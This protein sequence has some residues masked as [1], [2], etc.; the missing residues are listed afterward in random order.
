LFDGLAVLGDPERFCENVGNLIGRRNISEMD[1]IRCVNFA[2]VVEMRIDMLRTGVLNIIL[3]M[4]V[5]NVGVGE[6]FRKTL[7]GGIDGCR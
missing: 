5:R 4:I 6:Q 3:Y 1:E 7:Y 2:D